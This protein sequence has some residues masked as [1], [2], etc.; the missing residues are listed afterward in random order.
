MSIVRKKA[1]TFGVRLPPEVH[2]KLHEYA[3]LYSR[4]VCEPRGLKTDASKILRSI[5][6][7]FLVKK[8]LLGYEFAELMDPCHQE[9]A[10]EPSPKPESK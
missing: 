7:T 4:E 9:Y 2:Q 3:R 5:I 8:G 1:L 10:R 6:V